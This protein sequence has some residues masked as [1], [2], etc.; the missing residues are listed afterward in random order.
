MHHLH[1]ALL[2]LLSGPESQGSVRVVRGEA[3][4][5]LACCPSGRNRRWSLAAPRSNYFPGTQH[6]PKP[7]RLTSAAWGK[8]AT[9]GRPFSSA[10]VSQRLIGN[11]F[12]HP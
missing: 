1:R 7:T 11:Y 12:A 6:Q 4:L 2:P 5:C 9:V 3:R 10:V 8:C